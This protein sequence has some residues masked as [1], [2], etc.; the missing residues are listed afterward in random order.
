MGINISLTPEITS[1][2]TR[3]QYNNINGKQVDFKYEQH[4]S[5][6]VDVKIE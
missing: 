1:F 3:Y 4:N 2:D 5:T 6:D